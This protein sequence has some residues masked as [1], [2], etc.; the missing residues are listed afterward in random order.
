[1][2]R[3]ND[4]HRYDDLLDLPHHQS[5]VRPPMSL[6]IR[7][8]QFSPFAALTGFDDDIRE[9]GRLTEQK[10]QLD[11]NSRELLDQKLRYIA[12]HLNKH[13]SI[14]FTYFVPDT[15][16]EGGSYHNVTGAVKKIDMYERK[17]ILYAS[18]QISAG[19]ELMIEDIL[20]ISFS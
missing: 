17:I 2:I 13:C 6:L 14:T 19:A 5:A 9:T 11:E 10:I 1:M 16:K 3:N 4:P 20:D 18:N 12:E 7:A 8:A 15:L